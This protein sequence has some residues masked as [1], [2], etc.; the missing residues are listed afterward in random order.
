MPR[1]TADQWETI[2]AEREAGATFQSLADKH[3]VSDAAIVKKAQAE[4]W[5]DGKDVAELIRRKVSEKVSGIVSD[6]N[7]KKRAEAIDAAAER[8]AGLVRRHCEEWEEHATTFP[9]EKIK[10]NLTLARIGNISS[11]M[12]SRRQKSERVSHGLE[13]KIEV[14]CVIGNP[15]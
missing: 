8:G 1:L 12:I 2:R 4:G 15:R 6:A 3:G 13:N 9:L 11:E 7:P 14:D 10:E 5:S